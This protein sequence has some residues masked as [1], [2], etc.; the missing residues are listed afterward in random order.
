MLLMINNKFI[1]RENATLPINQDILLGFGIFETV[2][3]YRDRK[4]FKLEDHLDRLLTSAKK[5]GLDIKYNKKEL[6]GMFRKIAKK[7]PY[8]EQRIKMV[9]IPGKIMVIS[10]KLKKGKSIYQGINCLSIICQR[11]LPEIKSISHLPSLFSHNKAEQEGYF[12]AILTDEKGEVYEGSYCNIF[13]FEGDVLCTRKDKVLQG[14]TRK[15]VLEISPF[16]IKFKTI[17]IK[18]LYK[19]KEV[20][21]TSSILEIVPVIKIDNRKIGNGLPGKNTEK[22]TQAFL[23]CIESECK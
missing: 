6:L 9:A 2:R 12:E 22:L 16:K 18:D 1:S 14:N 15:A 19:M 23:S 3:T 5:I 11:S 7:S 4:F 13:W 17:S 8:K 21:T 10:I 20:F